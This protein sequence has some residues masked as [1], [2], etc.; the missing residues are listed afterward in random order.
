MLKSQSH[1]AL[2]DSTTFN[3]QS[4]S[5]LRK[6][7][8]VTASSSY[9]KLPNIETSPEYKTVKEL[10][11]HWNVSTNLPTLCLNK[12]WMNPIK[13]YQSEQSRELALTVD[14]QNSTTI[15]QSKR[16]NGSSLINPNSIISNEYKMKENPFKI[17]KETEKLLY[18]YENIKRVQ[19]ESYI[20][21]IQVPLQL[22]SHKNRE[23]I[24]RDIND[25]EP[26]NQPVRLQNK[27]KRMLKSQSAATLHNNQNNP[28]STAIAV[29]DKT[30][31][32]SN[33]Q[34][35]FQD[36]IDKFDQQSM[37]SKKT[38]LSSKLAA[39]DILRRNNQFSETPKEFVTLTRDI[40]RSNM[41]IQNINEESERLKDYI[42]MEQEK[43]REAKHQF[44]ED[45]QRFHDYLEQINFKNSEL[46]GEQEKL[47]KEKNGLSKEIDDIS[48]QI[49]EI[50]NDLKKVDTQLTDYKELKSFVKQVLKQTSK[51]EKKPTSSINDE[52]NVSDEEPEDQSS[53]FITKTKRADKAGK[54]QKVVDEDLPINT[55]QFKKLIMH[56]KKE[57]LFIIENIN[58]EEKL[59]EKQ[60][61]DT[62]SV[63]EQKELDLKLYEENLIRLENQLKNKK[64]RQTYFE[65]KTA[66]NNK[67]QNQTKQQKQ[68]QISDMNRL[69]EAIYKICQIIEPGKDNNKDSVKQLEQIENRLNY[70]LEAREY[71]VN[72]TDQRPEVQKRIQE[73]Y[74]CERRLD[75]QRRNLKVERLKKAERDQ[76]LQQQIKNDERARKNMEK[77]INNTARKI[78]TRSSKPDPER[79]EVEKVQ[80]T[81]EQQDYIKYVVKD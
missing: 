29:I 60:V 23:G 13:T 39:L 55:K 34:L 58:E 56:L 66:S 1:S 45:C 80:L 15:T 42:I 14:N 16:I 74:D 47:K 17:F 63:I 49:K 8:N 10:K 18:N 38:K 40:L 2:L 46:N 48:S 70:L 59:L 79:K 72:N 71:I 69:Y 78:M 57:N 44:D 33:A 53:V 4:N 65:Q 7:S 20:S 76:I 50:K 64:D 9:L 3:K 27:K 37:F 67:N 32:N 77:K 75:I 36:M 21:P 73:V 41:S 52:M 5:R 68:Q 51:D 61:K 62:N 12:G 28:N 54:P 43:I 19:E 30:L 26:L 31:D 81:Q 25:I 35:T 6:D 24:V 11:Q 22:K